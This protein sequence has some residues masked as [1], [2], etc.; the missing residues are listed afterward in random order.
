MEPIMLIIGAAAFL[1]V[2]AVIFAVVKGVM[3]ILFSIFTILII[4][5][6]VVSAFI[7][8]DLIEL[9]EKFPTEEKTMLLKD[10]N[11]ALTGWI[12]ITL[13]D[14]DPALITQEQLDDY[15]VYLEEDNLDAILGNS[16]KLM[17]IDLDTL[18]EL[19]G[20]SISMGDQEFSKEFLIAVLESDEPKELF[21][22]ELGGEPV[23]N[24]LELKA[25]VFGILFSNVG[26]ITL[27]EQYKKDNML[28]YPETPAFKVM[29]YLPVGIFKSV[30]ETVV[31]KIEDKIPN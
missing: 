3:K 12:L 23:M 6:L 21:R 29:K 14:E 28:F 20:E 30:L 8:S 1:V 15:S 25:A 31:S 18:R 26:P 24:E 7:A 27:V 10:E 4:L 16:Y 13:E 11:K 22:E 19:E 17:L 2:L 5:S 9:R